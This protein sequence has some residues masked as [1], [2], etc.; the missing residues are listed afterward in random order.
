MPSPMGL[1]GRVGHTGPMQHT[2]VPMHPAPGAGRGPG[3][4]GFRELAAVLARAPHD[5]ACTPF[6]I[7]VHVPF[8]LRRCGYCAFNTRVLADAGGDSATAAF[9]DAA[10]TELRAAGHAFAG[11]AP[12]V[13]SVYFGGGTPTLLSPGQLGRILVTVTEEFP[14]LAG[15]EV[16]V[17][18]NPDSVTAAELAELATLGVTRMSFGMQSAAPHVLAALDRTHDPERALHAVAEARSAGIEHVNLDLIH[19][20]PG[21]GADDWRRSLL[22]ALGTGIDHL[23]AYALSVEDG[24]KLAAR[25]RHDRMDRPDSDLAADH[26]ALA[27]ELLAARGFEWY[28]VSNWARGEGARCRHNLLYWRNHHWWGVG[29]GAHSHL[30]GLRWWNHAGPQQ[31]ADALRR[32]ELPWAGHEVVDGPG[33]QLEELMLGIRL[34]EGLAVPADD[35]G[36]RG[37]VADGLAVRRDG[38]LVLTRAG[39][40]LAD[41]VV[42]RLAPAEGARARSAPKGPP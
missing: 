10:V 13:Q 21:E 5:V 17:E 35:D 18:S 6:G 40:L 33:R 26:Y 4:P 31:C 23:S 15:A 25:V 38:R 30:A 9:V 24:T 8:C 11:R 42:R 28:E 16:T 20:T 22:A 27:D 14:V 36:A 7:Y 34:R 12:P 32:G 39:R 19:G 2:A 29:P 1:R 37:A 3:G 41:E